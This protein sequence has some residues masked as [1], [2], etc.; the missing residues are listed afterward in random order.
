MAGPE[1]H[2]NLNGGLDSS[3]ASRTG[4]DSNP[5]QHLLNEYLNATGE[6]TTEQTKATD[7]VGGGGGGGD[8]VQVKPNQLLVDAQNSAKEIATLLQSGANPQ[9]TIQYTDSSGQVHESTIADRVSQLKD[10]INQDCQ[11]AI[12]GADAIDQ[13]DI[14]KQLDSNAQQLEPLAKQ[15]GLDVNDPQFDQKVQ[16]LEQYYGNSAQAG[17]IQQIAELAQQ[18][19]VLNSQRMA[20]ATARFGYA[21]L[22]ADGFTDNPVASLESMAQTGQP[23]PT[24]QELADAHMLIGQAGRLNDEAKNSPLFQQV[25]QTVSGQYEQNQSQKGQLIVSEI[26]QAKQLE[27]AGQK[28]KAEAMYKKAYEDGEGIDQKFIAAQLRIPANANNP[29]VAQALIGILSDVKDARL[30]YA[31]FLNKQGKY[32]DALPIALKV[33]ADTPEFA[34]NDPSYNQI[35]QKAMFGDSQGVGDLASMQQKFASL[36]QDKKYSEAKDELDKI[37]GAYQTAKDQLTRD[38]STLDAQ[39]KTIDDQITNLQKQK[40]TMDPTEY[41]IEQ[42]RLNDEKTVMENAAKQNAAFEKQGGYYDYLTGMVAY[43]QGD[44]KTAHS[45]FEAAK[46][47]DPD[48]AKNDQLQLDKLIDDTKEKGW[49][50]RN[51]HAIATVGAVVAGVAVGVAVGCLTGPGGIAA[52]IGTTGAILA[53]VG[54]G[55]VAGGLAYSG[56]KG[57][58]VGFDKVGWNDFATGAFT[59]ALSAVPGMQLGGSL[60]AGTAVAGGETAIAA[61]TDAAVTAGTSGA[62]EAGTAGL[63]EAGATGLTEAGAETTAA[64]AGTTAAGWGARAVSLAGRFGINGTSLAVGTGVSAAQQ[65]WNVAYNGESWGDAAKNFA[66]GSLTNAM[67]VGMGGRAFSGGG[68]LFSRSLNFLGFAGGTGLVSSGIEV[69][70]DAYIQ[71]TYKPLDLN[72]EKQAA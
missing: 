12:T 19:D 6:S 14:S 72:N 43:C 58:A 31:N 29:Q 50:E 62:V 20:P 65:G 16:Q 13:K 61:G 36:M 5:H 60:L 34:Q 37:K 53:A 9:E 54:G 28:D 35:V 10:Q 3:A 71:H 63:T 69:G 70:T 11:N 2:T 7:K 49:F 68:T 15:F 59:G 27:A 38:D 17:T 56:I 42:Q 52:G 44:K 26:A 24:A 32:S 67:T 39:K 48:L 41:K 25:D 55:A 22:K 18:R 21:M 51:W 23:K 30:D 66:T 1:I 45:N 46:N 57:A 40:D 47:E 33:G 4:T 64:G 8:Q